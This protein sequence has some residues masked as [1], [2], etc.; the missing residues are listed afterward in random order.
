M[1]AK[2]LETANP[3]CSEGAGKE[4]E[5]DEVEKIF[6]M[7]L[8]NLTEVVS[9]VEKDIERSENLDSDRHEPEGAGTENLNRNRDSVLEN[10]NL[11]SISKVCLVRKRGSLLLKA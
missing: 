8:D 2:N 10:D 6:G 9:K 11:P 7:V 4:G 1:L 3:V 5:N